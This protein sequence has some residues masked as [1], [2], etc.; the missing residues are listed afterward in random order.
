MAG[1]SSPLYNTHNE[2]FLNPTNGGGG[3]F[4][5]ALF[6]FRYNF[7]TNGLFNT[8]SSQVFPKF[9]KERDKTHFG[10]KIFFAGHAIWVFSPRRRNSQFLVLN[11]FQLFSL[12]LAS[13][14]SYI[15]TVCQKEH[16]E[17]SNI[18]IKP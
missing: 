10:A 7:R 5:P 2:N 14:R 3:A 13:I 9:A 15:S 17:G 1:H 18:K 11:F 4:L 6:Y 8:N 16:F 12:I